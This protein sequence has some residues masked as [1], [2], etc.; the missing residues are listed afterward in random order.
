VGVLD[1]GPL[2]HY[3]METTALTGGTC[4]TTWTKIS[5]ASVDHPGT[6][7]NVVGVAPQTC[8]RLAT[9]VGRTPAQAFRLTPLTAATRDL[10][11]LDA[12]TG[13]LGDIGYQ[14][15]SAATKIGGPAV[16]QKATLTVAS[17]NKNMIMVSWETTSELSVT[18]FDILGIDGK[19]GVKVVGSKTCT[20]CNSGLGASYTELIPSGTFQGSKKVQIRMQ[21]SG[22]LSN[23]LDLK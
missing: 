16:S 22:D 20:Q 1:Q 18:G 17:K 5:G 7:M 21:P 23:T 6:T 8:V 2:I 13:K 15:E 4:G 9:R 3:D 14:V 11:R 19:G 10:N 12:Q